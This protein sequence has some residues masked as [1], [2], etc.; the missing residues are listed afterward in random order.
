MRTSLIALGIIG[1]LCAA[2]APAAEQNDAVAKLSKTNGKVMVNQGKQFVPGVVNA[3]L[4][5]GDKV[6][7]MENSSALITYDDGCVTTVDPGTVVT[8]PDTS[9]CK[10]GIVQVQSANAGQSGALGSTQGSS[11][12]GGSRGWVLPVA[13]GAVAFAGYRYHENRKHDSASP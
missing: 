11:F 1:A 2:A 10:G 9:P 13:I 6:L 3:P 5:K 4:L 12:G 8:V 7:A